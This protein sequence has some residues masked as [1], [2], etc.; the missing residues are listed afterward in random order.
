MG[1]SALIMRLPWNRNQVEKKE[2]A[3]PP[4]LNPISQWY[5]MWNQIQ[6]LYPVG[7]TFTLLCYYFIVLRYVNTSQTREV[8]ALVCMYFDNNGIMHEVLF[9][10]CDW[11]C[12][13]NSYYKNPKDI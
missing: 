10:N 11:E 12:L 2:V 4:E 1:R 8:P 6:I 3:Q 9:E 7:Y 13:I 5:N